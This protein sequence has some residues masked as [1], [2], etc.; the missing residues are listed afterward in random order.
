MN[1]AQDKPV[2]GTVVPATGPDLPDF[3]K[4]LADLRASVGDKPPEVVV[5]E[6]GPDVAPVEDLAAREREIR[7]SDKF[8]D[9]VFRS[10]AGSTVIGPLPDVADVERYVKDCACP[11]TPQ[12]TTMTSDPTCASCGKL[13]TRTYGPSNDAPPEVKIEIRA[14]ELAHRPLFEYEDGERLGWL[15]A[16]VGKSTRSVGW[17][18]WLSF[19]IEESEVEDG[20]A[21]AIRY[22][23]GEGNA[24]S[25]DVWCTCGHAVEEHGGDLDH[26]GSTSC[27]ECDC[28]AY[29]GDGGVE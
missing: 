2:I 17:A 10:A 24:S 29:E 6:R 11:Y 1:G 27:A 21:A 23:P 16:S 18:G 26:P 3:S 13:W 22:R 28:I 20:Q 4:L 9:D 14:A 15:D 25:K 8:F 19:E 12:F 7:E 5:L